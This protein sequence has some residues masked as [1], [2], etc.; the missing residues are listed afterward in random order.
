MNPSEYLRA[1]MVT[2]SKDYSAIRGRIQSEDTLRLMHSIMGVANES[3]E[4]MEVLKKE[5]FYGKPVDPLYLIE[6]YGDLLWYIAL[7][8]DVLGM[9]FEE[10]MDKNI[11]KLKARYKDDEFDAKLALAR[12]KVNE[13]ESM[14]QLEAMD[15]SRCSAMIARTPGTRRPVRCHRKKG[16]EGDHESDRAWARVRDGELNT[17]MA[18]K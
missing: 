7:G 15:Q 6:E 5:I 17:E 14:E 3:G 16:H 8:L 9:T 12:N 18:G 11:A 2:E 10:V 13:Y 4:L 1:T